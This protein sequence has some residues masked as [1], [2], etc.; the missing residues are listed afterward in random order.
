MLFLTFHCHFY[1]LIVDGKW[2]EWTP[3]SACS[4]TCGIGLRA[5]IRACDSPEPSH[6]GKDCL[7]DN[8]ELEECGDEACDGKNLSAI[9]HLV[10]S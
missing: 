4:V 5:R 6:G 9:T 1:L 8:E 3:W 10:N 7:G 2:S